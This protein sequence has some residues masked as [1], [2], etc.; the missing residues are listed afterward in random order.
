[1]WIEI[2]LILSYTGLVWMFWKEYG[3]CFDDT[4]EDEMTQEEFIFLNIIIAML[5]VLF[6]HLH[7]K[8]QLY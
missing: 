2:G 8:M 1:M 3:D 5:Q 6:I 7:L 4:P